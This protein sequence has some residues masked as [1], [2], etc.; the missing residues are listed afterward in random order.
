[1][2]KRRKN[3]K[4]SAIILVIVTIIIAFE[5]YQEN[6]GQPKIKAD[7]QIELISCV[8]GDTATF[9]KIGKTRFL[10]IDTP[11][12]TTKVEP[13]GKKAAY[14]TCDK[15][16]NAKQIVYEFDGPEKD[17][18]DRSLAWIFVDGEL[19]QELIAKEGY[20]KKYYD[21]KANYKYENR[22]RN[23]LNDKYHIF[24]GE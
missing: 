6:F 11:E 23:N 20:V 16:K 7:N 5:F 3:S 1:M 18:Y 2:A 24:E 15:L 10:F 14:F 12:S 17:R 22:I 9:S 19:L 13:Y 4:Y 21:Y 8:D